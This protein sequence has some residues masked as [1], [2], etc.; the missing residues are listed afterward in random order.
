VRLR[1]VLVTTSKARH[2]Y[3]RETLADEQ[4]G[5]RFVVPYP[6][7]VQFSPDVRVPSAYQLMSSRSNAKLVVREE[8]VLYGSVIRGPDL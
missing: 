6:T 8:D 4:G 1:L 3:L 5:Y 7:D 2:K